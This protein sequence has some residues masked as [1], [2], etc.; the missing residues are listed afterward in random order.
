M[1][2]GGGFTAEMSEKDS[3]PPIKNEANNGLKNVKYSLAMA[4]TSAPHS[5]S[6]QF[7][8]NV[9]DNQFLDFPGKDGKAGGIVHLEKFLKVWIYLI[10]LHLLTL[11]V[12]GPIKT[13]QKNPSQLMR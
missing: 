1:I 11:A 13:Y 3:M 4:R 2:Q 10:K 9:N 12:M 7:F 6:S 8:I 5:A